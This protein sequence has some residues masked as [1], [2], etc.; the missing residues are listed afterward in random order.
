M[1]FRAPSVSLHASPD[2]ANAGNG[3]RIWRFVAR[4][5]A[6]ERPGRWRRDNFRGP[7]IVNIELYSLYPFWCTALSEASIGYTDTAINL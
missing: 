3:V 5:A 7:G 1:P 2:H 4:G 6:P